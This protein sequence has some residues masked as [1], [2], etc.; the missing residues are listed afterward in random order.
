MVTTLPPLTDAYV[1]ALKSILEDMGI[2]PIVLECWKIEIEEDPVRWC[3]DIRLTWRGYTIRRI[4]DIALNI[5]GPLHHIARFIAN[6]LWTFNT[7]EDKE[8]MEALV[9]LS[10]RPTNAQNQRL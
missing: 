8:H 9:L 7:A 3:Y 6:D 10:M 2:A 1:S 4:T 5:V